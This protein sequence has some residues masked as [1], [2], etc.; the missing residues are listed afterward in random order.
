MDGVPLVEFATDER[1]G[2]NT[3]EWEEAKAKMA[4]R[5]IRLDAGER[6]D[7]K[8]AEWAECMMRYLRACSATDM[9]AHAT[10]EMSEEYKAAALLEVA[11]RRREAQVKEELDECRHAL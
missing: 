1:N 10:G 5:Q 3:Q 11:A 6:Y 4:D 8:G 2:M 7:K 9:A